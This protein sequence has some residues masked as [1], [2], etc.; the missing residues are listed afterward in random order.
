MSEPA[1]KLSEDKLLLLQRRLKGAADKAIQEQTIPARGRPDPLLH[2]EKIKY[3]L[4]FAEERMWFL[5][6]L[7]PGA[8][9]YNLPVGLRFKGKL[10]TT[11]LQ[12]SLNEILRRHEVLRTHFAL[13]DNQPYQGIEPDVSLT[14][15]FFGSEQLAYC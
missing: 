4:S 10:N 13:T 14:L 2:P 12:Q 11:L 9:L 1:K 8:A 15:T 3:P 7:D 5:D 6:Q